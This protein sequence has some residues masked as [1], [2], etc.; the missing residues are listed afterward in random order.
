MKEFSS[1]SPAL[2][3]KIKEVF[4]SGRKRGILKLN[5]A[6]WGSWAQKPF[7][8]PHFLFLENGPHSASV[9]F[10][11]FKKASSDSWGLGEGGDAEIKTGC[12]GALSL[13]FSLTQLPPKH[14]HLHPEHNCPWMTDY[15]KHLIFSGTFLAWSLINML[16][17]QVWLF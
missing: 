17:L 15:A 6:L 16:F 14:N 1:S 3:D 10:P 2:Q 5:R 11:E 8:V 9:A 12:L 13:H 4:P 7:C